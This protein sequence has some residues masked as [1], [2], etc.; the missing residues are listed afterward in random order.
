MIIINN[1]LAVNKEYFGKGLKAIDLLIL[2][3]VEEFA[4]NSCTCHMT[5][6]QLMNITGAKRAALGEAF[7]RLEKKN[8]I[9]RDTKT[10][11]GNGKANKRRTLYLTKN[12]R[13]A[14]LK[15]N[16]CNVEN[17][18]I[19]DNLKDNVKD[20]KNIITEETSS[21]VERIQPIRYY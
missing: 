4:R 19:K 6:S 20:N 15:N 2:A 3:Q 7:E 12:Y 16:V 5:D 17:Q 13:D 1:F 21:S 11:S 14:I 8:I 18:H 9:V 10:I